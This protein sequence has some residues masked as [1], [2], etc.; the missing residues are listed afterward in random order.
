[1]N[2]TEAGQIVTIIRSAWPRDREQGWEAIWLLALRDLPAE[3]ANTALERLMRRST[4][5]PSIAELHQAVADVL[6]LVPPATGDIVGE[7]WA[8]KRLN[9]ERRN[10]WDNLPPAP[11]PSIARAVAAFGGVDDVMDDRVAWRRFW[12]AWRDETIA[13]AVEPEAIR[14][15]HAAV[16][17]AVVEPSALEA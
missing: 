12:K 11:H 13:A 5:Q 14:R 17:S 1:M 10:A 16:F 6:G 8:E 7:E 15:A 4:F 3:P 2:A 9:A